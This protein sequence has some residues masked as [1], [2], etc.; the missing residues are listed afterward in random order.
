MTGTNRRL[1]RGFFLGLLAVLLATIPAAAQDFRKGYNAYLRGDYATAF[2][3]WE[4]LAHQGYKQAQTNLGTL[5]SHAKGV[6]RNY[7]LAAFWYRRAA[8]QG[9]ARAMYNLGVAYEFGRGVDQNDATA[10]EWYRQAAQQGVVEAMNAMAWLLATSPD[11]K[12]RDGR[13]AIRWAE[14][15]LTRRASVRHLQSLAA[16]YAESGEFKKA[17]ATIERAIEFLDREL[18]GPQKPYKERD[19]FLL[20]R[21]QGRTREAITLL[22]HLEFYR[23]GQLVRD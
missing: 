8:A 11:D 20:I 19:L 21:Q 1:V 7:P 17:I 18:S 3:E 2:K 16:A 5:Y 12:V 10:L 14:S 6:D 22:E 15:A 13:Q 23:S 9:S 4:P